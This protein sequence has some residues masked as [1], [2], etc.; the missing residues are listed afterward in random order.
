MKS[1]CNMMVCP[2]NG[3]RPANPV[4][5][6][7]R[8]GEGVRVIK[9]SARGPV[10]RGVTGERWAPAVSPEAGGLEGRLCR[11]FSPEKGKGEKHL[12][13]VSHDGRR[14]FFVLR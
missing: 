9:N 8:S 5:L 4:Y 14:T 11:L 12:G 10:H 6:S 7:D 1:A 2:F 13:S 3:L